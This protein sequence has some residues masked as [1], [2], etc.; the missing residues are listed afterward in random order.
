[1]PADPAEGRTAHPLLVGGGRMGEAIR[2][3]DWSKTSLGPMSAW[4]LAL[5]NTLR[6]V[7]ATRQPICL[8]WGPELL[9][10]HNDAYLPMLAG[11]P[12]DALGA[13]FRKFW[14]DVWGDVEGFVD[15]ALAG[16]GTWIED[17]PLQMVR[18]GEARP[19]FW[20]F[21]YSPLHDDDGTVAGLIN[22]VTETT[23][24]VRQ[25]AAL[26]AEAERR[27]VALASLKEAEKRQ[28]VLQRELTHRMKNT[29]AMVQSV[30]TQSLRHATGIKEGATLASQRIH[31]LAKA[32]DM[33]TDTNW[34]VADIGNVVEAAVSPH[35]DHPHR[36]TIDGPEHDLTAQQALGLSLAL[37]ELGTNAAKYGALS[38]DGGVVDLR[39]S[40]SGEGAL[41]FRWSEGGGP[42]VVAAPE[43]QGFGTRLTTR[44]VPFYFDGHAAIEYRPDGVVYSL[45]GGPRVAEPNRSGA[46]AP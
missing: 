35:R 29:L 46:L 34:E 16:R 20:T 15:E 36:F 39:W 38:T 7:L 8:W 40:V 33:L 4:P 5:L 30:V 19:T 43:R 44:V 37:H 6:T 28:R 32:Q 3:F 42:P 18:D 45:T 12:A 27:M 23:T 25:R 11:R 21:S 41:S 10:F 17:L 13:P 24:T 31:A 1:M 22:I 26:E 9:Q 14:A 2:A